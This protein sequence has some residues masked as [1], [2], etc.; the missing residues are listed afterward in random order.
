[1]KLRKYLAAAS[2]FLALPL[3]IA[4]G[5]PHIELNGFQECAIDRHTGILEYNT[6]RIVVA[7]KTGRVVISGTQLALRLMHRERL[8]VT[9]QIAALTFLEGG[10]EGCGASCG[11]FL[12]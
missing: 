5:L 2:T 3:D 11:S 7:L 10:G 4:A 6:E 9:G 1:M 8:C 12:G